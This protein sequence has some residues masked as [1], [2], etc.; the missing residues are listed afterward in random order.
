MWA[1]A[2]ATSAA[3]AGWEGPQ[4]PARLMAVAVDADRTAVADGGGRVWWSLDRGVFLEVP[5][6]DLASTSTES[7]IRDVV[8]AAEGTDTDALGDAI[9]ALSS[10]LE[11]VDGATALAWSG[12]TLWVGR[13]D[14]LWRV[15]P[16]G[17]VLELAEPVRAVAADG[18]NVVAG[19]RSGVWTGGTFGWS[20]VGSLP[21]VNDVDVGP[22][23]VL[24]ATDDGLW[25]NF[26]AG[27]A[28]SPGRD[29]S[30]DR[31]AW[32]GLVGAWVVAD[33]VFHIDDLALGSLAGSGEVLRTRDLATTGARAAAALGPD[34][35]HLSQDG[36]WTWVVSPGAPRGDDARALATDGP[37]F[38]VVG[39]GGVFTWAPD[40]ETSQVASSANAEELGALLLSVRSR[41]G[42]SERAGNPWAAVALPTID[43]VGTYA[44]SDGILWSPLTGTTRDI[45][46][47]IGIGVTL[48]WT[49]PGR[50]TTTADS[51]D[52]AV[53]DIAEAVADGSLFP[54]DLDAL[55][56]ELREGA[57]TQGYR[58]GRDQV[59]YLTQVSSQVATAW[60]VRSELAA[61]V[62]RP[63]L[64]AEVDRRLRL[65]ELD[66]VIA[67]LTDGATV[68]PLRERP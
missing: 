10:A 58:V 37:G 11:D 65:A 25:T 35:L 53:E 62:E 2:W 30:I 41:V 52:V 22:S 39:E 51:T 27:W 68:K 67:A 7:S 63:S 66:A 5:L 19:T 31:V 40:T 9:D 33:G 20:Q 13:D 38:V 54:E 48:T 32:D 29:G 3:I 26:G 21:P 46:A 49:P 15:T 45:G 36:G 17:V 8:D 12:D 42:L 1:L 16:A 60:A 14:G 6:P 24:A 43:L 34:G 64:A 50:S 47:D 4:G 59:S 55:R 44:V 28:R 23:G 56:A 61:E 57:T 18:S